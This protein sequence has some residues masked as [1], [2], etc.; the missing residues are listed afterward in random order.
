M[1]MH[2]DTRLTPLIPS[3]F[4]DVPDWEFCELE[5]EW[6]RRQIKDYECRDEL[7]RKGQRQRRDHAHSNVGPE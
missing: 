2:A 4:C 5:R 1:T 6:W 7:E 3:W